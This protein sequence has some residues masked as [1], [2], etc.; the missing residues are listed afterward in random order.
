MK[1]R[2]VIA[3]ALLL[4]VILLLAIAPAHAQTFEQL[5]P[6]M[7]AVIN[8]TGVIIDGLLGHWV[9]GNTLTDPEGTQLVAGI[10]QTVTHTVHFLAQLVIVFSS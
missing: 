3:T 2:L 1:R 6:L 10:A 4:F 7:S 5:P 9:T 8:K